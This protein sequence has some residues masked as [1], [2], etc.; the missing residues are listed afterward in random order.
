MNFQNLENIIN[1]DISRG[2]SGVAVNVVFHNKSIYKN[3]FGYAY[4]I[5]KKEILSVIHKL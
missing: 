5:I 2:F 3:N 1:H 4:G